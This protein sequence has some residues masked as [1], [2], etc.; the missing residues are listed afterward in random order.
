MSGTVVVTGA[1]SGIGAATVARLTRHGLDVVA[2]VRKPEDGERLGVR[3]V[4][5][6]VTDADSIATAAAEVGDRLDG[7]VNNAGVA[8]TAPL[9][10]IPIDEL[11]HQL[12]VNVI[13]QVAV[14]QAFLPAL[15]NAR[16]RIVNMSSIGGKVA[17]PLAGPY[18][19]SKFALEAVSDSLRRELRPSGVRVAVIEPGAVLTPIWDKGEDDADRVMEEIGAEKVERMYGPLVAGLRGEV[20]KIKGGRGVDPDA[21]ARAVEHALTARRPRTRYLV[22]T[23]AKLRARVARLF[24]DRVLDAAIGRQLNWR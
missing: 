13:G 24:P 15:R 19:A 9:E 3:W 20:A 4:R 2:G 10:L 8:V 21:V 11:R 17:L 22:G 12:E 14:T 18:A 7:L 16:G 23:D 5:L 6:D 1:S